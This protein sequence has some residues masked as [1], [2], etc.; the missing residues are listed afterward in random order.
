MEVGGKYINNS[1]LLQ[2]I[3]L[4]AMEI[5]YLEGDID[6]AIAN[7]K[8]AMEQNYI[9]NIEYQLNPIYKKLRAH[10]DWP[11][12]MAESNKRAAIQRE[13]YLELIDEGDT[14]AGSSL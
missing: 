9:V 2:P 12:I 1:S 7:L 6:T 14:A 4:F 11:S 10:P 8:K 3:E 5:A 13:L